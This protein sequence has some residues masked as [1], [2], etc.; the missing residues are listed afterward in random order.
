MISEDVKNNTDNLLRYRERI[1]NFSKEFEVGL[2]IYLLRKSR[3]IIV[4]IILASIFCAN[5]YLRYTPEK[6]RTSSTLQINIKD[7]ADELLDLYSFDQKSNINAEVALL[8]SEII[9]SKAIKSLD[10]DIQYFSEGEILSRNIYKSSP[11]IFKDLILKDSS[12]YEK[13]IYVNIIDDKIT[14]TDV[15]QELNYAQFI[16]P[17]KFFSSPYFSGKI[18]ILDVETFSKSLEENRYYF[19]LTN[20]KKLQQEI[21]KTLSVNISD[22]S[23][24]TIAISHVHNNP[25]ITADICN[26]LALEYID[27]AL[28]KQRKSSINIGKYINAQKDSVEIR[29]KNSEK[30]IQDYKKQNDVNMT[31]LNSFSLENIKAFD[32]KLITTNLDLKMLKEMDNI[33]PLTF[34]SSVDAETIQNLALSKIFYNDPLIQGN[35]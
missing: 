25:N 29:L 13:N 12:F 2:F 6:H 4:L 21:A 19:K 32:E 22:Y 18:Q 35:D 16:V 31:Q 17:N 8:K 10:F 9:L 34:N 11:F 33:L 14:L 3:W 27:Y 15:N 23:A 30:K 5:I 28:D 1:A 7:Q 26:Q 20:T 24:N